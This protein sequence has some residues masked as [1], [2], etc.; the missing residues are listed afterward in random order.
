MGRAGEREEEKHQCI[1]ASGAPPTADVAH[2]P[3]ICPDW[4]S[5]QWPFSSQAGTE[6][7]EPHQ[8]NN[9]L[10]QGK[11]NYKEYFQMKI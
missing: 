3:G 2:N 9:D 10:F 5:N 1:V 11:E 7:T 4:E 6:S 8:L